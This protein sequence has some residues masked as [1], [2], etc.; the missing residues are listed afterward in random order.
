MIF[1]SFP[2]DEA[3]GA[4]LAHSHRTPDRVLKKGTVLDAAGIAALRAAGKDAVIA[5]RFE[6]GDIAEND[7]ATRLAA[8]VTGPLVS[9]GRAGTGRVNLHADTAGLLIVDQARL[10]RINRVDESL[11]VATLPDSAVV[12]PGDM[13][14]T[15]KVIPFAVPGPLLERAE[16]LARDG[17]A[18]FTL[19]PFRPLTVGLV[20]CE[21]PGMKESVLAGTVEATQARVLALGG[22]MLPSRR[23]AHA[24]DEIA[25]ALRDMLAE[26]ADLLLVAGASATVDRRDVGPSGVV[27]A[28]GRIIHFG[29]PV[30]P[31]NLICTCEIAGKP[32]L[33]LPGCARSPRLNGIDWVLRRLFAGLPVDADALAAMGVGGLLKDT[34]ARPLPRAK[35]AGKPALPAPPAEKST[36]AA[37]VLAAGKSTRMAPFNKL[38]IPDRAGKPM[39]ARV[40]DNVLSS[41]ARP[42]IVVTGHRADDIKAALGGRPVTY[43]ASPHYEAG[44]SE[45]LKAGIAALPAAARAAVVCLGD[46]PLVTGRIIDRLLAA[47]DTDQGRLIAVPTHQGQLGNPILW[48]RRYFPELLAMTGDGGGGRRI[49][50][51]HAE[52]VAEIDVNDDAVLRDFDTQESLATLPPRLRPAEPK[53]GDVA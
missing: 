43:V 40:V 44:L 2:L 41:A 4:V 10:V 15:I 53:V 24:T 46:M 33:V 30:D 35:A 50:R 32:A 8:A 27:A 11:T 20:V 48:D 19:H 7:A 34:A 26:G 38:L 16:A 51:E 49:L 14:A 47:H 13:L 52:A 9:A 37:V 42:V 22:T 1:T 25:A 28:G 23:C 45:S 39:I 31:G 36:I 6:P 12:A 21:L 18:P 5:A 17:R 29:M 3:E